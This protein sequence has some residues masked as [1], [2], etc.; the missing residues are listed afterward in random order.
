MIIT[1]EDV[2]T[3]IF[4]GIVFLVMGWAMITAAEKERAL[5]IDGM[6]S[7][8]ILVRDEIENQ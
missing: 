3:V 2:A 4:F 7:D 8:R 5:G 6:S 1:F